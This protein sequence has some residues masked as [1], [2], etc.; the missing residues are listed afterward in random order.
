MKPQY[1][2]ELDEAT[3]GLLKY[4]GTI[5]NSPDGKTYYFLP[6]WFECDSDSDKSFIMH[7]L[8]DLP[9]G[10]KTYLESRRELEN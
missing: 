2:I 1:K 10:L 9:D 5:V 3:I 6:Y 8:G 7:D 4:N